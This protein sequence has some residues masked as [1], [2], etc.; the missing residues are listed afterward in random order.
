MSEIYTMRTTKTPAELAGELALPV[1]LVLMKAAQITFTKVGS[2]KSQVR[3]SPNVY[4]QASVRCGCLPQWFI[5][6]LVLAGDFYLKIVQPVLEAEESS[7]DNPINRSSLCAEKGALWLERIRAMLERLAASCF[8]SDSCPGYSTGEVDPL[9][10][11][12]GLLLRYTADDLQS[13]PVERWANAEGYL[14]PATQQDA[15][16]QPTFEPTGLSGR[17]AVRFNGVDQYLTI[18]LPALGSMTL[19]TVG[20]VTGGVVFSAEGR[21][22]PFRGKSLEVLGGEV[23]TRQA[24]TTL[25]GPAV[26]NPSLLVLRASMS[27]IDV[28]GGT[29]TKRLYT[30]TPDFWDPS[31]LLGGESPPLLAQVGRRVGGTYFS[32]L[33]SELL[34]FDRALSDSEITEVQQTLRRKWNI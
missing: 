19:V 4:T 25:V 3:I 21:E 14:Y 24:G 13:S 23:V 29:Q 28:W 6:T 33:L 15:T 8:E 34:L 17:P 20:T 2:A 31:S 22:A 32:G 16:L 26:D 7:P 1:L 5:S 11:M 27:A 30:G 12:S 9:L 18:P 10:G